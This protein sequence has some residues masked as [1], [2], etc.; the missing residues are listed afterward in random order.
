MGFLKITVLWHTAAP[1]PTAAWSQLPCLLQPQ[2]LQYDCCSHGSYSLGCCNSCRCSHGST[3]VA[4]SPVA[5]ATPLFA[6]ATE[7][8]PVAAA[9]PELLNPQ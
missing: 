3:A 1:V 7:A 5:F 9:P 4:A 8:A 2:E 6:A